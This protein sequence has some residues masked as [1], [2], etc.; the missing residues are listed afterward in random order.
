MWNG[1]GVARHWAPSL[2]LSL[3]HV[4]PH[5]QPGEGMGLVHRA[6]GCKGTWMTVGEAIE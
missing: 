5:L 1:E 4:P 6:V 2:T 3:S